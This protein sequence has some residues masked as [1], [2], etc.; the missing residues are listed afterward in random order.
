VSGL[1][2]LVL[3]VGVGVLAVLWT[4]SLI[5]QGYLYNVPADGLWWRA[6]AGAVVVT[7]F[8]AGWCYL[9]MKSDG[10]YDTP[11]NFNAYE[12][13]TYKEMVSVSKPAGTA[14]EQRTVYKR[15]QAA[16]GQTEYRDPNGKR[17]ER[18]S[19]AGQVVALE[20]TDDDGRK[21]VFTADREADGTFRMNPSGS[22]Q[23]KEEGGGRVMTEDNLGTVRRRLTGVLLG[24]VAINLLHLVVWFAVF[25]PVLRYTW[26]H[27]LGLALVCWLV[28]WLAVLP[29]LFDKA[30]KATIA[31]P[32]PPAV[33]SAAD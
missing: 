4:G 10:R 29:M 7:A 9:Y 31:S 1:L 13:K 32:P 3:L 25:W 5:A 11:L 20:V 18:S 30:G 22:V 24:N 12:S 15:F 8:I 14:P 16:R 2:L 26:A 28:T 6:P 33:A 21:V 23:F 27:A 17:W 19:S